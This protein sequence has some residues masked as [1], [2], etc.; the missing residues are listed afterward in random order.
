MAAAV[1]PAEC[2]HSVEKEIELLI[3]GDDVADPL[4]SIVVPALNEC[5]TI[6]PRSF[7]GAKPAW[8][9]LACAARY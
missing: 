6:A 5:V 8:P 1:Y 7:N 3:P 9:A 2:L 4:L